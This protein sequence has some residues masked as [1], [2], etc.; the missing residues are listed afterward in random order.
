MLRTTLYLQEKTSYQTSK[1]ADLTQ[2]YTLTLAP[3]SLVDSNSEVEAYS[4]GAIGDV[5][6]IFKVTDDFGTTLY[7]RNLLMNV[8]IGSS[9]MLRN[10][11]TFINLAKVDELDAEC[12]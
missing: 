7:L 8:T 2:P 1:L 3:Y 9:Y 6:T 10:P 11:P 12:K 4:A 5:S